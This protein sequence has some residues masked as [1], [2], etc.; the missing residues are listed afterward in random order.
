QIRE[1]PSRQFY[2]DKLVDGPDVEEQTKRAWHDFR[3]FGPFCFFDVHEGEELRPNESRSWINNDEVEFVLL[4]YQ[5]LVDRYPELKSS[6]RLAMISPYRLQVKQL[7]KR[8]QEVF[9]IDSEK[10]VDINTV[11]GFQGREKDVA[12]FTCVR[13]NEDKGK[14]AKDSA[15]KGLGFVADDQRMNVGITRAKSS[16]LVVGR[17]DTLRRDKT[18]NNLVEH[19]EKKGRLFK[20]SKPYT[21]FW[22]EQ[23][24]ESMTVERLGEPIAEMDVNIYGNPEHAEIENDLNEENNEEGFDYNMEDGA[25]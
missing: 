5:K 6:A 11:D 25:D 9:G 21:S 18:W 10:M 22:T 14:E 7:R 24:L 8:F 20:V 13:A 16:I 12:I 4:L 3:C 15:S 19:A 17:A 23:S 2:A 1:F